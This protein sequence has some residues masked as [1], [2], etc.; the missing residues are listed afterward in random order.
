M[1]SLRYGEARVSASDALAPL[2]GRD[3]R[4]TFPNS[5]RPRR[6]AVKAYRVEEMNGD[7]KRPRMPWVCKS[8]CVR[9]P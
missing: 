1:D 5:E 6:G 2:G 9:K 3:K 8:P 7:T 4:V